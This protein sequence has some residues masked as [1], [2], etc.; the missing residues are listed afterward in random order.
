MLGTFLSNIHELCH[1]SSMNSRQTSGTQ[2][3]MKIKKY[4]SLKRKKVAINLNY[5]LNKYCISRC[6]KNGWD[7]FRLVA[8][9]QEAL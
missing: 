8:N 5:I 6:D 1:W 3:V 9:E 4:L 7:I 2:I